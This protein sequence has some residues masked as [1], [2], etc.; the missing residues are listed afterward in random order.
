MA[1]V[2]YQDLFTVV[3]FGTKKKTGLSFNTKLG[4]GLGIGIGGLIALCL[5]WYWLV[6]QRM[7]TQPKGLGEEGK[8][9]ELGDSNVGL[10]E[11]PPDYDSVVATEVGSLRSE[12]TAVQSVEGEGR[13]SNHAE[14]VGRERESW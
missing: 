14:H 8:G 2:P 5:L 13:S 12:R 11:N 3:P 4:I 9:V 10:G 7:T 1:D 6:H